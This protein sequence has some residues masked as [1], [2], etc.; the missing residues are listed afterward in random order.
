MAEEFCFPRSLLDVTTSQSA[1]GALSY[2]LTSQRGA[3]LCLHSRDELSSCSVY[4]LDPDECY[5]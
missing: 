4:N 2:S 1:S 3:V 5:K